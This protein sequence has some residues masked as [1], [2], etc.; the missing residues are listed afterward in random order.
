MAFRDVRNLLLL[1]HDDGTIN[2][3]EFLVLN[4]LYVSKNADFPYDSY[5]PFDLEELDESEC[6]AEFRFRKRDIP[7]LYNVLQIPDTLTCNQRSV[8]DGV[9]GLCMLL[10]RLSYPC[11]Y[12]DM[13]V[14][15]AKPVPVLSM[16]TNQMIDYV[17]NT[18]GHKVLQWN[19]QVLSPANLQSY[20]DAITAKGAP[21]PNC[22]GF[23]DGTVRPI[24]RPGEHQRIL[25]NGHKRVHALKFQSVAL[26]NG[27]IGNLYGPVG[28]L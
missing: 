9:E 5:T 23:I 16:V 10:K 21:L 1:S 28:K 3:E 2:D 22:F 27:L 13:I 20:V 15:F 17:Y 6:L 24:S 4:D 18:H 14:R 26:P 8:C 7:R 25:Y 19:H 12:G 11:R